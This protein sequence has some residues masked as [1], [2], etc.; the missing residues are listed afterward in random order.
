[1]HRVDFWMVRYLLEYSLPLDEP[2]VPAKDEGR[3]ERER[4]TSQ[5]LAQLYE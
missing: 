1:M 3:T 4:L 2:I 5:V